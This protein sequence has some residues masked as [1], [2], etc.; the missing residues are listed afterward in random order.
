MNKNNRCP[1]CG[2][3]LH[4]TKFTTYI[5]H[6]CSNRNCDYAVKIPIVDKK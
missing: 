3:G 6:I 2:H 1:K 4:K 5:S